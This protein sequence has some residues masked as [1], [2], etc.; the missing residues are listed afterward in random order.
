MTNFYKFF[1]KVVQVLCGLTERMLT[2][3]VI[4]SFRDAESSH[5]PQPRHIQA[6]ITGS[7]TVLR[8]TWNNTLSIVFS[9]IRLYGSPHLCQHS[10]IQLHT[11]SSITCQQTPWGVLSKSRE[12]LG[13]LQCPFLLQS[14]TAA[15][16][17]YTLISDRYEM[18]RWLKN[19]AVSEVDIEKYTCNYWM[20]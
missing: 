13:R 7:P 17:H 2:S 1:S 9:F 14:A 15:D 5:T 11:P 10:D 6:R 8:S 3:S 20:T 19:T 16:P 18:P 4:P 12:V